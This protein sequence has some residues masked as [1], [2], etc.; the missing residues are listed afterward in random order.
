MRGKSPRSAAG[1][2][3]PLQIQRS[4]PTL[5][6]LRG[7]AGERH[8]SN[9]FTGVNRC[10]RRRR[11]SQ[12]NS[13]EPQVSTEGHRDVCFSERATAGYRTSGKSK[14]KDLTNE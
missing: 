1:I 2:S 10:D 11:Q 7:F 4:I 8:G 9:G 6:G 13:P 12:R 14:P 3:H 5:G